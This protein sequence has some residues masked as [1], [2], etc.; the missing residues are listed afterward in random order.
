MTGML[1][2]KNICVDGWDCCCHRAVIYISAH[3][4]FH[5]HPKIPVLGSATETINGWLPKELKGD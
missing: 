3:P 2:T 5:V 1:G 4:F